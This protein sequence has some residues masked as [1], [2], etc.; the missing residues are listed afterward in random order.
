[1]KS[2]RVLLLTFFCIGMAACNDRDSKT[3]NGASD[4]GGGVVRGSTPQEIRDAVGKARDILKRD[5]ALFILT[6]FVD[7]AKVN[8]SQAARTLLQIFNPIV[9]AQEKFH[10]KIKE[11]GWDDPN[12]ELSDEDFEIYMKLVDES[13]NV[14][15]TLADYIDSIP[16][17]FMESSSCPAPYS[18]SADASVSEFTLNAKMCFSLKTLQRIPIDS[19]QQHVTGLLMHELTHMTGIEN[20]AEAQAIEKVTN[21]AYRELIGGTKNGITKQL[22]YSLT[23]AF[24]TLSTA[25]GLQSNSAFYANLSPEDL[26]LYIAT[27][28]IDHLQRLYQNLGAAFVSVQHFI[29]S[30]DEQN[31]VNKIYYAPEVEADRKNI[32]Q[33]A[34][35]LLSN[36]GGVMNLPPVEMMSADMGAK[37]EQLVQELDMVRNEFAK[38]RSAYE[39]QNVFISNPETP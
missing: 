22:D 9:G 23:A 3:L 12:I 26:A 8:D 27:G 17:E 5:Q 1:M 19:L 7:D 20:E 37:F 39:P 21:L 15:A 10:S 18:S 4:G 33:N 35:I 34:K 6:L 28:K 14:P 2:L 36:I 30:F 29:Y 38:I 24:N 16:L 32:I 25:K 11:L 31:V 13:L